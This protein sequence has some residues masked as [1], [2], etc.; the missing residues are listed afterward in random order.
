MANENPKNLYDQVCNNIYPQIQ[1]IEKGLLYKTIQIIVCEEQSPEQ[2]KTRKI[3]D[4]FGIK[5]YAD[6]DEDKK[7]IDNLL[8]TI[9]INIQ[10]LKVPVR[11]VKKFQGGNME[12]I[13]VAASFT[14]VGLFLHKQTLDKKQQEKIKPSVQEIKE[15]PI[16]SPPIPADL[17]LVVP[18]SIASKFINCSNLSVDELTYLIDSASYFLCTHV[19]AADSNEKLLETTDEHIPPDSKREVYIRINIDDGRNLIDKKIPY[20]LKTNLPINGQCIVKQL[21]CLKNLSGLEKFNRV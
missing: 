11:L 3:C 13:F 5:S 9:F 4:F 1:G 8:D 17:C 19:K 20:F 12:W 18:A 21:A 2:E 16:F 15:Q 14:F 6:K 7:I 10:I